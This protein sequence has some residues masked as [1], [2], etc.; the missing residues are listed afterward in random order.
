MSLYFPNALSPSG[1][2]T[3]TLSSTNDKEASKIIK[4]IIQNSY[5]SALEKGVKAKIKFIYDIIEVN[6][7]PFI[8]EYKKAI[9]LIEKED[10]SEQ[11]RDILNE[12]KENLNKTFLDVLYIVDNGVGFL[13]KNLIAMLGDGI[14]VKKEGSG[15][16]YGNG[17]F[18]M[19]N[20]SFLRY[21]LYFSKTKEGEIFSGHTI[22][23]TFKDNGS[24]KD[25]N[26][27][28]LKSPKP[29]IEENDV[30]IRAIPSFLKEKLT[31]VNSGAGIMILGFNFFLNKENWVDLIKASV[32]RNFFVA[33]ER[34]RLEVE[35]IENR[36]HKIDTLNFDVI[37][38]ETRK[39][40]V[41]PRY[42]EVK[43]FL[44]VLDK[45]KYICNT[46]LGEVEIYLGSWDKTK[47]GISRNGMYITSKL[48]APL[49]EGDFVEYKPFVALILPESVE[50]SNLI[51]R[52]EGPFHDDI[53]F[54]RFSDD[55]F[56]KEKR[57]KLK[58]VFEEINR[59]IKS[60]VE[61][62]N[63]QSIEIEIPELNIPM[64]ESRHDKKG[65]KRVNK[66][67]KKRKKPVIGSDE[68]IE[69]NVVSKNKNSKS[70]LRVGKEI[71]LKKFLAFNDI[72]NKKLYLKFQSEYKDI[73]IRL[74][75]DDGTD[76][77]CDVST[78]GVDLEIVNVKGAN[79]EGKFLLVR[80]IKDEIELI[81]EYK[82]A[83]GVINYQFFKAIS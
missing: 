69:I 36:V 22:L 81:I 8:N 64:L 55:D 61:K 32:V 44:E 12:I 76:E 34:D 41:N 57:K 24:L 75:V 17:H 15:G 79:L 9:S 25:K 50:I 53:S 3:A 42:N 63:T 54:R 52:A 2:T 48:P 27:Y 58:K 68:K 73:F 6:K 77:T 28:I 39:I 80:D 70:K 59:F 19:F 21:L 11:E 47:L 20:L 31:G 66:L 56:G 51:K 78:S 14:S 37:F 13:K 26:G 65:K 38:E 49:R 5:D 72:E 71:L 35:I 29:L 4:E 10:L 18:S 46:S 62:I 33:L 43:P 30:F 45:E 60:K 16:S 82:E 40:N 83:K 23:R 7:I 74:K 67:S 1:F